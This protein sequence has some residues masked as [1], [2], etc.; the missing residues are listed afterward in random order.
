VFQISDPK[1][2]TYYGQY[3]TGPA[4]KHEPGLRVWR[5][6]GQAGNV[7]GNLARNLPG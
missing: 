3:Q 4:A 5:W 1:T 2:P 7:A 6:R